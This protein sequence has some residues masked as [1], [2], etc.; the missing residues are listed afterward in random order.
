MYTQQL[1]CCRCFHLKPFQK[2]VWKLGFLQDT[3]DARK[4]CTKMK[5]S[6]KDFFSKC[7]FTFTEEILDGKFHLCS[8]TYDT[9]FHNFVFLRD[10]KAERCRYRKALIKHTKLF[11]DFPSYWLT[12][13]QL[14]SIN[15]CSPTANNIQKQS[16]GGIL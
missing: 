16:P 5:F 13:K 11:Y 7:D 12:F 10:K 4:H 9:P 6:I 8:E 3:F 2:L 1:V 15:T 14:W